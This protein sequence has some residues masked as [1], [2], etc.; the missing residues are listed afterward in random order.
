MCP[1][2][3]GYTIGGGAGAYAGGPFKIVHHTT[4]GSTAQSAFD[5]FAQNN[6]TPHFTVDADTIYQHLDTDIAARSLAN[7]GGGVETNRLSALQIEIVGFAGRNKDRTTLKHVAR[8]CRWLEDQ[9]AVPNVWPSGPPKTHNNGKDPGGHNRSSANW[10]TKG[11]HYGHS[12]VPENSHWDPAY[13]AAELQFLS[14]A[15][16]ASDGAH[17]DVDLEAL[18]S[19]DALADTPFDVMEDHGVVGDNEPES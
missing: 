13:S 6:S 19:D 9:H 14:E 5:T 7:P 2:A 8:L 16:F 15:Q 18:L 12:Q 11:G 4:E 17:L 3:V 10:T 1:F